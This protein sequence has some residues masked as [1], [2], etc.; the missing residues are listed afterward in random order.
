MMMPAN[1]SAVSENEMT[2][3]VG[4][5]LVDCLAPVMTDANWQK[6][7]T[8]V[9]TI[10][11]NNYVDKLVKATLGKVFNGDYVPGNV[12]S[13]IWSSMSA[14]Y[15]K[16]Y[17]SVVPSQNATGWDKFLGGAKGVLNVGLQVVGGL[18]AIYNLGSFTVKSPAVEDASLI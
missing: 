10:I 9:I 18:A 6:V 11:G 3:V 13:G 4:G 12:T 17:G 2:Y 14:M 5:G 16:N 1:F 15:D 7:S 8:N